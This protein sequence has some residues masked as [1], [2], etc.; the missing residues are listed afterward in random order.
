MNGVG[1]SEGSSYVESPVYNISTIVNP[2]VSFKVFWETENNYD[3]VYLAYA[4]NGG[5]FSPVGA[6]ASN[7]NCN[8]LNWF[9]TDTLNYVGG[10]AGWSGSMITGNCLR[11]GGPG[12]WI[13]AKHRLTS[14]S[15]TPINSIQFRFVFG[16]GSRCNLYDG[17]AFDDFKIDEAAL[18]TSNQA[19]FSY[20]CVGNNKVKFIFNPPYCSAAVNWNFDDPA[21][22]FNASS[23]LVVQGM[24]TS[25]TEQLR[26]EFC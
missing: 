15:A 9:N 23:Q 21:S 13:L 7:G 2:E 4:I 20:T 12:Q 18:P 8:G 10:F 17:F 5:T 6:I 19:D 16:A 25:V 14:V 24:V 22:L 26:R 1:Y 11:S 3:G